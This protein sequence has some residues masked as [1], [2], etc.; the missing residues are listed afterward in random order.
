MSVPHGGIHVH[1]GAAAQSLGTTPAKLTGFSANQVGSG[2]SDGDTS[3]TPDVANDRVRVRPGVYVVN[4][5][6]SGTPG[7]AGTY[8]FHLRANQVEQAQG[9]CQI[10]SQ[11]FVTAS[12]SPDTTAASSGGS[13][14]F[15]CVLDCR[16]TTPD[17]DGFVNLEVYGEAGS[18]LNYTPVHMQL[19]ALRVGN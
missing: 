16:A 13:A 15:Q 2:Q 18:T 7:G 12:G 4:F 14:G 9:A 3:V 6:V 5:S 8:Q 10:V 1:D 11:A 17:A 19:T